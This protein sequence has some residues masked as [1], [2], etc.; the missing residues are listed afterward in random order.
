MGNSLNWKSG[1]LI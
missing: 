1:F